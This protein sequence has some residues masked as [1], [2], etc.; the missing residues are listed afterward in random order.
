MLAD[1]LRALFIHYEVEPS[2]LQP[3]VPF[4]LDLLEGRAFVSV[5]AFTMERLRPGIGGRLSQ[6]LFR[7]LA[8]T[9]FLNVR[10][11]VRHDNEAG[12]YFIA[13]FISNALAVPLGP[14]TYGLPYRLGRLRF[15]HTL[16]A[17]GPGTGGARVVARGRCFEAHWRGRQ[18]FT[19]CEPGSL[20][21][22]LLERYTAFTA[23]RAR[24]RQFRIWHE[25]WQQTPVAVEILDARLLNQTWPWF[26]HVR[27]AGAHFSPGA[28]D[29]WMSG[30]HRL[31]T[32]PA[33]P[34]GQPDT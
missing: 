16:C 12:I 29:V 8:T 7:P 14:I 4:A 23:G 31:G 25:P 30:P 20:D 28:T 21:E 15:A 10:T 5:V 26:R 32:R 24:L 33:E 27:V 2:V 34:D 22:F 18:P 1:W 19:P 6:W 17:D 3:A 9:R 13:E 11:Y